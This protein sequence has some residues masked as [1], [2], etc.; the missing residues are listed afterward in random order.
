MIAALAVMMAL[1][2]G[3]PPAVPDERGAAIAP[4][5]GIVAESAV[6]D[7]LAELPVGIRSLGT[8]RDGHVLALLDDGSI[9]RL[10]P[11]HEP[12]TIAK[13]DPPYSHFAIDAAG[14]IVAAQPGRRRAVLVES[15]NP[16]P[17]T[18]TDSRDGKALGLVSLIA[19]DRTGA[20]YFADS[21]DAPGLSAAEQSLAGIYLAR[22]S[23]NARRV[24]AQPATIRALTLDPAGSSLL[25]ADAIGGLWQLA[26]TPQG[27]CGEPH[28]LLP[29]GAPIIDI[30]FDAKG[31]IY[32]CREQSAGI[33]IHSPQGEL[34]GPIELPEAPTSAC[35]GRPDRR[36]L[37]I[38]SGRR[39]FAVP[40][41]TPG[42]IGAAA[43]DPASIGVREGASRHRA[44]APL[45]AE[46]NALSLS[47]TVALL[48][49]GRLVIVFRHA[50]TNPD[51][52]DTQG[53]NF[54]DC[55]K[56]RNL[57]EAGREQARVLGRFFRDH[58]I[59]ISQTLSSP[60][61][62]AKETAG[63]AFG[64]IEEQRALYDETPEAQ[65]LRSGWLSTPPRHG[66]RILVT[67]SQVIERHFALTPE[68]MPEGTAMLVHPMGRDGF[69]F[70]GLFAPADWNKLAPLLAAPPR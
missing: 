60:M 37:A 61:C 47:A 67:H 18:L 54:V 49:G 2:L 5:A 70:V 17:S 11:A 7:I 1:V 29:P 64:F 26:I 22:F 59:P 20:V 51:E 56:Q 44:S 8:E 32:L 31:R 19:P 48:R 43:G 6:L 52:K 10:E 30:D 25:A 9:V 23:G 4:I 57:S 15:T 33:S 46:L 69:R 40:L 14:A 35:F 55:T 21:K 45:K 63:L 34:L 41:L 13:S 28:A 53:D 12:V 68:Q 36:T 62:R 39:V 38:A 42:S 24:A 3:A 50:T 58:S 66:N 27:D 65:R 16:N